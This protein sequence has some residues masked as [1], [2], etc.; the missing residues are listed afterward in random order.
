[1]TSLGFVLAGTYATGSVAVGGLM[2]TVY[3]I[4][5]TLCAPVT[6]RLLDRIGPATGTPY[7]LGFASLALSGLAVAVVLKA[8]ALPLLLLAGLSGIFAAGVTSAMRSLLNQVVPA[9]MLTPA[10]AFNSIAVE[11]TVVGGPLIVALA[12]IP[13]EPGAI[14]AMVALTVVAAF[15][16]RRL[17]GALSVA[18]ETGMTASANTLVAG[19]LWRNR[20]F[21]FWMA[22]SVAFGHALGTAETGAFPLARELGGGTREAAFLIAAMS[23]C[24]VSS[25]IAYAGLSHRLRISPPAQASLLLALMIVASVGL[26]S[27]NS[28]ATATAAIGLLGFCAAPLYTIRSVAAEDDMP[29]DRRAEGFGT[30]FAANG[31]GFALGGLLLALLPLQWMLVAGGGSA[32]VALLAAPVVMRGR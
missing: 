27:S 31:L 9:R 12:A 19:S 11:L 13:G 24:S 7:L 4:A 23:V 10:L 6:G 18:V 22:V 20:R 2:V 25:G 16:V 21:L 14:I 5:L 28:W 8:S 32:L 26:G 30:L 29:P 3:V 15:S 1:M 17:R